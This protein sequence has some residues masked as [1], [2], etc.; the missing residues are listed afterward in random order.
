MAKEPKEPEIM[1]NIE[2]N[3]ENVETPESIED[4]FVENEA[5]EDEP[6]VSEL[7]AETAASDIDAGDEFKDLAP[8]KQKT[9]KKGVMKK[10]V[11]V[12]VVLAILLGVAAAAG[13]YFFLRDT[14]TP[15]TV[16]MVLRGDIRD[17]VN[18][19]GKVEANNM[20]PINAVTDDTVTEILVKEGDSVTAG[21]NVMKL[22]VSGFVTSPKAGKVVSISAS[23]NDKVTGTV[24]PVVLPTTPTTTPTTTTP[25]TGAPT[26]QPT[27]T[28]PVNPT[29]SVTT[30]QTNQARVPTTLMTIAEMD[31]TYVV[32]SVDETDISK[33]KVGQ[34]TEMVLDAYPGKKVKGEVKE[35]GLM[36]TTTQTGGTAFPVKI[37]ITDIKGVDLRIGMSAN[38]D[39]IVQTKQ[40]SLRVPVQAVTTDGGKDVVYIVKGN[41][42]EKTTVRVGLLSGDYYELLAGI[43]EGDE[44]VT[45]GL[46][47]LKGISKAT[48][49]VTRK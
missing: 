37:Q 9:K 23:V 16:T 45:N 40:D 15:V 18:A 21:Q 49:K 42:A 33:I 24:P 26:T 22:E 5:V 11:A 39:V 38:V 41:K 29:T 47:K 10:I 31:P 48:V 28:I 13:Y 36:A 17:V 35:I 14:A 34:Q 19:T 25:T 7:P 30:N 4:V 20:T 46:D 3:P 43:I 12:I 2:E 32:A 6:V 1:E 44:V 8:P 27:T